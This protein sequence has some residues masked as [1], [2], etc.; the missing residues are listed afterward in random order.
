[1]FLMVDVSKTGLNGQKFAEALF[2]QQGI[3]VLPAAAFGECAIDFIRI[4]YVVGDEELEDACS[5]INKFME[6]FS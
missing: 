4:S 6:Q 3:A 1:M 5:R 2:D